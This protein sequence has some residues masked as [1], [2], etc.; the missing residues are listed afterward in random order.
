MARREAA[1]GARTVEKII[2][3]QEKAGQSRVPMVYLVDSAGARL[4][5]QLDMFPGDRGAGTIFDTQIVVLAVLNSVE[6][7]SNRL[8]V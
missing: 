8:L 4:T 7:L 1:W 3:I 6:Y 5:D 2:R